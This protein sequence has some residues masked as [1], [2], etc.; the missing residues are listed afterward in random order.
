MLTGS[1]AST[2]TWNTGPTTTTIS[3]SPASN[4]TYTV[5]GTSAVGCNNVGMVTVTVNPTPTVAVASTTICVGGTA[6]LTASGATTYS[7]S[8]GSTATSINPSPASTTVYTVTGTTTGCTDIRTATVTV[9][10]APTV[11]VNS[12]TIC[13][14]GST[15]LTASGAT[16]YTWST[17][18]ISTSISVS[19][20]TTTTY[21]VT[22]ANG[23]CT[24]TRTTT[25]TV[26]ALPVVIATTTGTNIC[27]GQSSTLTG[28][29]AVTYTWNPGALLGNPIVVTPASSITYTCI[30]TGTNGCT[31]SATSQ[32]IT[33]NA[34]PTVTSNSASICSG[35]GSATLTA[36]G[37][38]TYT[39]N[40]AATTAAIVVSP[41]TTT[42]YTVT[43]T[44]AA[45]CTNNYTTQVFVGVSP[46]VAVNNATTCAG[47]TTN[48]TASGA[49]TYSWSTGAT[50]TSVSV[51]P[52]ITT[53]YTVTGTTG[54][55][56]NVQTSTVSVNALPSVSL[57]TSSG[58]ACTGASGG[59]PLTLTGSPAGGVY[60]GPGVIG[61]T[62]TTQV[63]PGS[64][65]ATYSYTNSTTGCSNSSAVIIS[66]AV[67]TGA[68][69]IAFDYNGNI[70]IQPNPNNG[71]FTINAN[72]IEN[73]E[74]TIYN[75][76]GQ[77]VKKIPQ[78]NRSVDVNLSE[79]GHGVYNIVFS[80]N[81]AYTAKKVIVQ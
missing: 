46:T 10:P 30:A 20:T 1:G 27:A 54:G 6:T 11:A 68:A 21:S 52:V 60:S 51:S 47:N 78:T 3:V 5:T 14:G 22:G 43:G 40:T 42:N 36:I 39:W 16:T 34:L 50:T 7:W 37:A 35:S 12:A 19:P 70:T 56:T 62:F 79:F 44:N 76:I 8:T 65:T 32:N 73:Y 63:A 72:V 41:P 49:T 17:G 15:T 80:I 74:V 29:G 81:G 77:L 48:L 55:C 53:I 26:N 58:T 28:S 38:V 31:N 45:G 57:A 69:E 25:V 9:A 75:S 2:Y 71:I 24:N 66:V 18:P 67:C 4:T 13:V 59:V 64:Y 33:V 61:N 23:T